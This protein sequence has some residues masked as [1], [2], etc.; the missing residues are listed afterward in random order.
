MRFVIAPQL[1]GSAA[2]CMADGEIDALSRTLDRMRAAFERHDLVEAGLADSAFHGAIVEQCGN[3]MLAELLGTVG[4][5]LGEIQ[6]LPFVRQER[7]WETVREHEEIVRALRAR[8]PRA[9]SSAMASHI[10]GA[11]ERLGVPLARG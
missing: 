1:A 9:A 8:D 7:V 6:R 3:R 11:A 5:V 2:G 4:G 10:A